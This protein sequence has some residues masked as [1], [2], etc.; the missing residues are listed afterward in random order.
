MEDFTEVMEEGM[1]GRSGSVVCRERIRSQTR[2]ERRLGEA[3]PP[4]PEG[5]DPVVVQSLEGLHRLL[6]Q[7]SLTT[8]TERSTTTTSLLLE[9]M[10]HARERLRNDDEVRDEDHRTVGLITHAVAS[11]SLRQWSEAFG[12]PS[13]P[14]RQLYEM[15]EGQRHRRYLRGEKEL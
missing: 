6:A 3:P 1:C 10:S 4:L 9:E 11:E 5:F 13:N 14:F 2:R 15:Q 7:A 8:D 12:D